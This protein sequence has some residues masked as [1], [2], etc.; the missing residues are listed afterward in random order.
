M[1]VIENKNFRLSARNCG[2]ELR[3]FVDKRGK[4]EYEYLWQGGSVWDG[5]SPI[6][7]PIVGRLREDSYYLDNKAYVLEKHGFARKKDFTLEQYDG[8]SM[9]FLLKEDELTVKSYPYSFELRVRFSLLENG[10]LIE[11]RVK[12]TG[13]DRM[14]FS[15][16]A[17][18]GFQCQMGDRIV[19]DEPE[20]EEAFRFDANALRA[21][22]KET[23][24]EEG[25]VITIT[26]TIFEKDALI[27]AGLHS[28][29]ASL[30][31]ANGRNVH[32]DFGGAPC[33]GLWAK[34]GADYVCIEPWYGIDDS[35]DATHDFTRKEYIQYLEAGEEF[36]FPVTVTVS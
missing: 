23:V 7:F 6:L 5:C 14:Y 24:F 32:V 30:I 28:K 19:M 16:G 9:T 3:S 17:H 22:E 8:E 21:K 35:W 15:L 2:A 26:P 18:P 20:I 4:Q 34:P 27:F 11:H 36:R 29:G 1:N 10:F 13:K 25:G 12:N 33:L 31:R